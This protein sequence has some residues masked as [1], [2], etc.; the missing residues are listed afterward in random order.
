MK[1]IFILAILFFATHSFSQITYTYVEPDPVIE[2][3]KKDKEAYFQNLISDIDNKLRN[4]EKQCGSYAADANNPKDPCIVPGVTPKCICDCRAFYNP[5]IAGIKQQEKAWRADIFKREEDYRKRKL[6]E[7]QSEANK[8]I[9]ETSNGTIQE[10]KEENLDPIKQIQL[11]QQQLQQDFSNAQGASSTAFETALNSGKKTSGAMLDATLAGSQYISD[12]KASLAYTG[13]GL[14]VALISWISEKKEAQ[15]AAMLE[16]EQA[17]RLSRQSELRRIKE[18]LQTST[19]VFNFITATTNYHVTNL[20]I[21]LKH[22]MVKSIVRKDLYDVSVTVHNVLNDDNSIFIYESVMFKNLSTLKDSCV[23]SKISIPI[24]LIREAQLY[25]GNYSNSY[26]PKSNID[27]LFRHKNLTNADL[28]E[29]FKIDPMYNEG[30]DIGA[31]KSHLTDV[32]ITT[33]D[34]YIRIQKKY[35][36]SK[37][38]DL[39]DKDFDGISSYST[40]NYLLVFDAEDWSNKA[41]NF[42]DYL[43]YIKN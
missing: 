7:Q 28:K 6:K 16:R 20:K 18:S 3:E 13:V 41:G 42:V 26:D 34:N 10:T 39:T 14:S 4:C 19:L 12:P 25:D 2:K 35:A 22:G 11:K 15:R 43:N 5:S 17:E 32:N 33:T 40:N 31:I 29:A 9:N 8:V 37:P 27:Q 38:L 21:N 23:V 30:S 24:N 36:L 1:V